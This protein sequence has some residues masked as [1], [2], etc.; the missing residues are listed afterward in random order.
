MDDIE[1]VKVHSSVTGPHDVLDMLTG[2][3]SVK[4]FERVHVH[5]PVTS[6][7]GILPPFLHIYRNPC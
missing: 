5:T 1:R 7:Y 2:T 6:A 3:E 4:G